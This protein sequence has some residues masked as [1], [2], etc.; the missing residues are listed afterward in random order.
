MQG[1]LYCD[2]GRHLLSW[3]RD[4]FLTCGSLAALTFTV[5]KE[6]SNR[7]IV[8]R[9]LFWFITRY[10][11]TLDPLMKFYQLSRDTNRRS[12][13]TLASHRPTAPA[14]SEQWHVAAPTHLL[15]DANGEP[16]DTTGAR[17]SRL[18]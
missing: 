13:V 10:R 8:E 11:D 9:S 1:A 4:P 18:D 17:P 14:K 6:L 12:V 3:Q 5:P 7:R 16:L 2:L 15:K